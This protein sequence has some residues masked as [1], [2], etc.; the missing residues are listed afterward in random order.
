VA[1]A[2]PQFRSVKGRKKTFSTCGSH[3]TVVSIFYGTGIFNYMCLGSATLSDKD[4]AVGIFNT[5][6]NPMLNPI[7]YSLRKPDVQDALWRVI[8]GRWSLT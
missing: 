1:A 4:K 7:I 2:V 6:I 8:I 3:L 5:V